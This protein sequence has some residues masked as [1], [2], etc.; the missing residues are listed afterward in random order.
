MTDEKRASW[1]LRVLRHVGRAVGLVALATVVR[2]EDSSATKRGPKQTSVVRS[3]RPLA[4]QHRHHRC[5]RHDHEA[6]NT[7]LAKSR[8]PTSSPRSKNQ[9]MEPT[10]QDH[11]TQRNTQSTM[12]ESISGRFRRHRQFQAVARHDSGTHP[13]RRRRKPKYRRQRAPAPVSIRPSSAASS[14]FFFVPFHLAPSSLSLSLSLFLCWFDREL[15]ALPSFTE[16][17]HRPLPRERE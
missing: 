8:L 17:G 7:V 14:I 1:D 9:R 12:T 15:G 6:I 11:E 3:W 16:F 5:H 4:V 10:R 13:N 2:V